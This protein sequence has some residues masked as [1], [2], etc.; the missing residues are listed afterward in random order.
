MTRKTAF[1]G[2]TSFAGDKLTPWFARSRGDG[3]PGSRGKCAFMLDSGRRRVVAGMLVV[4][5]SLGTVADAV[6]QSAC[7]SSKTDLFYNPYNKN[8]AHHRP[9][10]TGATY[11]SST[12]AATRDWLKTD[13]F[14]VNNGSPWG[15]TV[16]AVES[17]DPI[18]RI[19]A[20]AHCDNVI[21]LP[22]DVRLPAGGLPIIVKMNH[23]G[24]PDGVV[25]VYDRVTGTPHHLRQFDWNGGRPTAGQYKT[26]DMRGLGHGTRPGQRMGTS[27]SGV[28]GLFGVLRGH[29]LSTPGH[30]IEHALRMGLPRKPGCNIMLSRQIVAPATTGDRNASRDGYNT[31]N[32][33]Y[34]AL[35]AIPQSVNIHALGLSEVGVRLAEAMQNYGVYVTDGSGCTAGAIEA[36]QEVTFAMRRTFRGDSRKIHP[37]VRM[38]LNN[39]LSQP[40]AGGGAP[41]A[42]NCAFDSAD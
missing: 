3:A 20:E 38:V 5:C 42:P 10:G 40:V 7:S 30:K 27:A 35:L 17:T 2:T 6:A 13:R 15:T 36:D 41:L 8:S 29:E 19:A 22:L 34:G 39:D 9:I 18:L 4:T 37:H 12:H 32:I 21:G 26:F 25:V 23:A 28:T 11:A 24:C 1:G 31:G 14:Q 33:P 16:V